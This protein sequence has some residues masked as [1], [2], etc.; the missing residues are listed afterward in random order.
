[1]VLAIIGAVF[2]FA[3]VGVTALA[4][5]IDGAD[6]TINNGNDKDQVT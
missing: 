4:V 3:F 1:M 6:H 2:V 5:A